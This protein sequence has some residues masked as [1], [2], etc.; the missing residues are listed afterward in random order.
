M[1]LIF[2]VGH[3]HAAEPE[4]AYK[5]L[6]HTIGY[7]PEVRMFQALRREHFDHT[8]EDFGIDYFKESP[9]TLYVHG[10]QETGDYAYEHTVEGIFGN[11]CTFDFSVYSST[12]EFLQYNQ[13]HALIVEAIAQYVQELYQPKKLSLCT[14]SDEGFS[15]LAYI[16]LRPKVSFNNIIINLIDSAKAMNQKSMLIKKWQKAR[17][18]RLQRI[19]NEKML[20]LYE[21][22]K[23]H[24]T[25]GP[26][27]PQILKFAHQKQPAKQPVKQR[28]KQKPMPFYMKI[29]GFDY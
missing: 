6:V 10:A 11:V 14:T 5:N 27:L 7:D 2:L 23:K 28:E 9:L 16:A 12:H 20:S 22:N 19:K 8:N 4:Q 3:L 15:V 17:L 25:T 29:F 24:A 26:Q 18:H 1:Y 13:K 21:Q